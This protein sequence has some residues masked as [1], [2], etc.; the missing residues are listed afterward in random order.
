M[1][2]KINLF[3]FIN[4]FKIYLH[5]KNILRLFFLLS[6]NLTIY[7]SSKYGMITYIPHVIGSTIK[8]NLEINYKNI[9]ITAIIIIIFLLTLIIALLV[10][11]I[12]RRKTEKMLRSL[13]EGVPD[14]LL[15]HSL[16]GK[17]LHC[18]KIFYQRYGYSYSE[19]TKMNIKDIETP[20]SVKLYNDRLKKQIKDRVYSELLSIVVD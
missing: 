9:V 14:G 11:I 18:N 3:E 4:S 6:L 8:S 10:S 7:S 12:I 20:D 13:A 17:I 2:I 16:N 19:I 5:K 15:V 1:M